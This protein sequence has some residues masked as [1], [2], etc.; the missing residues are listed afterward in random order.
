MKK[1][2]TMKVNT[3]QKKFW[4]VLAWMMILFFP[5]TAFTEEGNDKT[6]APYFFID[7][8]DP[9]VDRLP[10]KET[11][12]EINISGVIAEVTITQLY[13]NNGKRPINARYI[14]PASTRAAVHDMKMIIGEHIIK[15]EVMKR[16][17]AKKKYETAKKKGKSASLLE[18]QR[19][20]V[21][22]MSVANIIPG[23]SIK[24]ELSYTEFLVP[25]EGVY[26]FVFPTVVGPRYSNQPES[27]ASEYDQWVKNPYFQEES[28]TG[29]DQESGP[30][31]PKCNITTHISTGV[32]LQ[33]VT[34]QTHKTNISWES[35]SA[36]AITLD[37]SE[38][39]SGDRDYIL[40]YRLAGEE[41][42]SGLMMVEGKD[43]NFFLLMVQPPKRVES[44][45]IPPREYIFLVDV[46]GSMHG[47]PLN[48]SK[49]LLRDL[50]SNLRPNDTFN[51]I[52]FAGTAITMSPVSIPANRENIQ[53]AVDL[54]DHQRGGGGTEMLRAIKQAMALP[55]N[56]ACSRSVVIVTDG[57]VSFEKSVFNHIRANL[58][59]TNV[60]AFGIGSSVNRYLIEGMAKAGY[61]EPF[62]VT[63]PKEASSI[64]SKF[65]KYIQSPVLTNISVTY[66]DFDAYQVEP[67]SF[68][69]LLAERPIVIFGKWRGTPNGT[70]TLNGLTGKG[71]YI[72]RFPVFE[73]QP[74]ETN[75]S[76][77]YLWARTRIANLS[78]FGFNGNDEERT[79]EITSLGLTYNLL[80]KYTSFVA[81][82][83][84][85][86]NPEGHSTD[87]KQPLPLPRG[88][89]KYAVGGGIARGSEPELPILLALSFLILSLFFLYKK[90]LINRNK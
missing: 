75:H 8:G 49:K 80:T 86:R 54:I 13:Q 26:E 82:H 73:T 30:L 28:E 79:A 81:V 11:N 62:V 20:N 76:I 51:V 40:K 3:N 61:G 58:N 53:K 77:R 71:K 5:F 38:E 87:V 67:Q 90:I 9:S 64:A 21:F 27:S 50:I 16:K 34:I 18:Q 65:R 42:A 41:I 19:P 57:Y 59:N 56:E 10:L 74:S 36:A 23:D 1:E 45:H 29:S 25:T 85:I 31:K 6:L 70:I 24:V 60:F 63:N 12:A 44:G 47:F 43:E 78:D 15:A 14:F 68:P 69:D 17:A 2:E 32:P 7:N 89:S 83:E 72:Q 52:L 22:S 37:K 48:T 88:V 33:E 46:S 84:V 66:D 4:A 39:K 55:H 35:A